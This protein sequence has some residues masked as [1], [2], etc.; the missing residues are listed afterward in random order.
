MLLLQL[1][2]SCSTASGLTFCSSSSREGASSG[3]RGEGEN[4]RLSGT[5]TVPGSEQ[6][7]KKK[8]LDPGDGAVTPSTCCTNVIPLTGHP[9]LVQPPLRG[10]VQVGRGQ[11]SA[12]RH[13]EIIGAVGAPE[14]HQTHGPVVEALR[15]LHHGGQLTVAVGPPHRHVEAAGVHGGTAADRQAAHGKVPAAHGD[16]PWKT[17]NTPPH[18]IGSIHLRLFK[19]SN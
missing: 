10:G 13:E 16:D 3:S 15:N 11:E 9:K 19:T 7:K 4:R 6:H 1:L 8:D 17:T 18:V 2:L 5:G 12:V 14:T